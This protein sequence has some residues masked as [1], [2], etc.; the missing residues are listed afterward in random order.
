MSYR[1][2]RRARVEEHLARAYRA[3]GFMLSTAGKVL[4]QPLAATARPLGL[5]SHPKPKRSTMGTNRRPLLPAAINSL[6]EVLMPDA[7]LYETDNAGAYKLSYVGQALARYR[8]I[9]AENP[10]EDVPPPRK[11]VR[12]DRHDWTRLIAVAEPAA[13]IYFLRMA[14]NGVIKVA[15]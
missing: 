6:S 13:R 15:R 1:T 10:G 5:S 4:A 7:Q 12:F 8:Q 11:I 3:A 14:A 2:P 9:A